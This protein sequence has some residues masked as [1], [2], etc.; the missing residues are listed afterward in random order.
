MF[1]AHLHACLAF[2]AATAMAV[3]SAAQST[4]PDDYEHDLAIDIVFL[5]TSAGQIQN[6][7][8]EFE[9]AI[10]ILQ[11]EV[12]FQSFD[13]DS[14]AADLAVAL[15]SPDGNVV[16]FGGYDLFFNYDNYLGPFP[17]S[18][19]ASAPGTY[20][21]E[22]NIAGYE[23][24]GSGTW[25][26]RLMNGYSQSDGSQ[27]GGQ[28]L[29]GDCP[30]CIVDCNGNLINDSDD[31]NNGTSE[32]CDSNGVPDECQN[33]CDNDGIPDACELDTD[34][35]YTPDDCEFVPSDPIEFALSGAGGSSISIP[36]AN[37]YPLTHLS[38][39]F[40]FNTNDVW[41]WASDLLIAIRTPE[42]RY[43]QV[44]GFDL[45][46]G[47]DYGV[48]PES[49]QSH[50]DGQYS[51]SFT[52]PLRLEGEPGQWRLILMNGYSGSFDGAWRGTVNPGYNSNYIID[53]NQN[54][55]D[56]IEEIASGQTEDCDGNGIPDT[57][58]IL[59]SGGDSNSDGV[60]D[61]C[62]LDCGVTIPFEFSGTASQ[63]TVIQFPFSASAFRINCQALFTNTQ[64]DQTW[65]GDLLVLLTA[66]NGQSVQFGGYDGSYGQYTSVG[67]FPGSW[68]TRA[69]GSYPNASIHLG[70]SGL[71]GE[72][73]WTLRVTNGFVDS[74]GAK[75]AGQFS[76]CHIVPA[77]LINDCD[78]NGTDDAEDI[79]GG[80]EDCNGNGLPDTCDIAEGAVD[81]NGN[82]RIDSCEQA[83]GDLNLDG[84]VDGLDVGLFWVVYG[85]TDPPYGDLDGD[86]DVDSK[87][88]GLLMSYYDEDCTPI[89]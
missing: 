16:H 45:F 59:Q 15:I 10:D 23:L 64:V 66:P 50:L 89:G 22:F 42:G 62:Q 7:E 77:V 80:S 52:F 65:A 88:F 30:G 3:S 4:A 56:D 53:C 41:T 86:G 55:L 57:C 9:G 32:D 28:L 6:R 5:N 78:N 73:D 27:W 74:N 43:I 14:W 82:D 72:G 25:T 38:V 76:I 35:D 85:T 2:F 60:L 26:M 67:D 18:W 20:Y 58:D 71:S 46:I 61:V 19:R 44:G 81:T 34:R 21:H 49:M 37:N 51:H 47:S 1:R 69:T 17:D 79:S 33:D 39:S 84:C 68:D 40:D 31:I 29:I 63:E 13:V 70:S 8:F 48:F 87:D 24:E 12:G 36:F 75:W 54:G 83:Q 11:I